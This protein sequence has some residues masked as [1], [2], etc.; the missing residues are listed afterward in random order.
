MFMTV[1]QK[2]GVPVFTKLSSLL[3]REKCVAPL[4]IPLIEILGLGRA[5]TTL[6]AAG[7]V[8]AYV[9]YKN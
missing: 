8:M 2:E 3:A 9:N 4:L 5:G 1:Q 6:G 7:T